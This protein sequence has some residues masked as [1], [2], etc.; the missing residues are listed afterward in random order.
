MSF[1]FRGLD[2]NVLGKYLGS[3]NI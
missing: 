1:P 2:K 3:N